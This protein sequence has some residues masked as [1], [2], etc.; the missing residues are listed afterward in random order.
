M[1][2]T[3]LNGNKTRLTICFLTTSLGTAQIDA[4][5]PPQALEIVPTT[6]S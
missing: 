4:K 1:Y 6:A 3:G 5:V 2:R